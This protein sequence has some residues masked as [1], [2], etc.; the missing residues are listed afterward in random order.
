MSGISL[1]DTLDQRAAAGIPGDVDLLA[2]LNSVHDYVYDPSQVAGAVH[3]IFATSD[4]GSAG[5]GSFT[6]TGDYISSHLPSF[7]DLAGGAINLA[8]GGLYG[9]T[10]AASGGAL[11]SMGD[12]TASTGTGVLSSIG[13]LLKIITDV[14]RMVT[15]VIGL[16]FLLAGL[17]LLGRDAGTQNTIQRI[18]LKP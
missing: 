10:D 17:F 5:G 2:L 15:L 4:T 12:Q 13:D 14:P 6:G 18:V 7:N 16:L 1:G 8:T 9:L 3:N 11:S